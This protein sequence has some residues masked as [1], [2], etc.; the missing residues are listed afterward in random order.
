[1]TSRSPFKRADEWTLHFAINILIRSDEANH[2]VILTSSEPSRRDRRK[3]GG[4]L[5]ALTISLGS[6]EITQSV[7]AHLIEISASQS[8]QIMLSWERESGS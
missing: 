6:L 7:D 5:Q 8:G 4:I 2:P 1:M 3:K